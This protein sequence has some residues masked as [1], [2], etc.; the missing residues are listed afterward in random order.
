MRYEDPSN[1]VRVDFLTA[2]RPAGKLYV[3]LLKREGGSF[4]S[5]K[6][7]PI[8]G[9]DFTNLFTSWHDLSIVD[10]GTLVTVN[11]DGEEVL[12]TT[13]STTVKSGMKGYLSNIA[14]R[15][16]WED[17]SVITN[18][19]A[20]SPTTATLDTTSTS[21]NGLDISPLRY[22]SD[23]RYDIAENVL[24]SLMGNTSYALPDGWDVGDGLW[25]YKDAAYFVD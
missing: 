25:F 11:L 6:A 19:T 20:S 7:I 14:T 4:I 22:N 3:R 5:V 1:W 24:Y 17:L 13:Y 12:E 21:K 10:S 23:D 18:V 15:S 9:Y 8:E 2:Y 16:V